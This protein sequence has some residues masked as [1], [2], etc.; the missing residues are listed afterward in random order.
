M[1]LILMRFGY[2]ISIVTKDDRARYY[3]ALEESH[4]SDLT[5]FI[6]LICD[7]L[8]ESL[9]EYERAVNE[10][11]DKME[12]ARSLL[13]QVKTQQESKIRVHYEVWRS[14]MELMRGYFKQTVDTIN[15]M[16]SIINVNFTGY[17][18]IDFEKY[19]SAQKGVLIKRSWFFRLDFITL[20]S[21]NR[22]RYMFFF[23]LPSYQIRSKSSSSVSIFISRE[24]NPFFYEKL[25]QIHTGIIPN[26]REIVYSENKE[27]FICRYG[28]DK[29]LPKK[30]EGFGREF[31]EDAIKIHAAKQI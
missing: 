23:G 7:T 15:E 13:D 10:N 21:E 2:P 28:N 9:D 20:T 29:I 1:N 24:E 8:D 14:A 18:V 27:S 3:D 4:S 25:D 12:W 5:P 30:V 6:S 31:I 17:D 26:L 19:L 11:I 22:S 16:S